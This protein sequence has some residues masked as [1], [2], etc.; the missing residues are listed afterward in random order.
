MALHALAR[1]NGEI[2]EVEAPEDATLKQLR[3]IAYLQ[4]ME[5]KKEAR[6][7]AVEPIEEPI[8]ESI[9]PEV[10][11]DEPDFLDQLEEFAKGIPAGGLGFAES[12]ALGAIAPLGEESELAARESILDTAQSAKDIFSADPGSEELVG[13][14]FG[15]ALGSFGLMGLASLIPGIGMPLAGGLAVGA[16]AGEQSERARAANATEGERG[17]ATMLGGVVGLGE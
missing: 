8:E 10:E 9:L 5:E 15:E 14:K 6:L 11:V 2:Y 1:P 16:G 7:R 13:R 4:M 3:A 17:L 12:A